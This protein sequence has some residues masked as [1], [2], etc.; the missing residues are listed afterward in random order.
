[1]VGVVVHGDFVFGDG[2]GKLRVVH[3]DF[4]A[5]VD[6]AFVVELFECPPD[7]F[8]VVFVHGFVGAAEVDPAADAVDCRL[9]TLGVGDHGFFGFC[10]VGFEANFR[11]DVATI[12]N[13]KLLF[14]EVFGGEAVTVPAPDAFDAMTF[15]S[16]VARD[17]IFY[18]GTKE[19]AV[20]G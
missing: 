8:H 6:F 9:P 5:F 1:M 11:A 10:D 16:L 12:G 3:E 19:S 7:G 17:A 4:F 18:D 2:G 14:Y 13:A 15:H 20:M